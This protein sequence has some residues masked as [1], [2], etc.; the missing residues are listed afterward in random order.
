M[1][2][3]VSLRI[4]GSLLMMF[5]I[6][7]VPP[8]LCSWIFSDGLVE[9]F[10]TALVYTFFS[11]LVLRVFFLK[12]NV[13]MR[14]RDGFLITVIYYLALGSF[15]ALPF[16]MATDLDMSWQDALFESFSGLTTTGATVL[17]GLDQMAPSLLYYRQQLQWLGGMGII[18]LAVAI[19]PMLGI[20]G[21]QL[22]RA[23]TPGPVKD[24]KM[25]P[26]IKG[27]AIALWSIYLGLTCICAISYWL[28]GMSVFDAICHSFSTLAIGGFSTHD[29]SIGYFNSAAIETVAI[30]FMIIAGMNFSLHFISWRGRSLKHYLHDEEAVFYLAVL[31]V[32]SIVVIAGLVYYQVHALPQAI[33]LGVFQVVSLY[34]TTG[35]ATT[36]FSIWPVSLSFL[37]LIGAFAGACAGSTGGGLKIMRVL[38]IYKQGIREI[39]RLIHPNAIFPIKLNHRPVPTK[40]VEAVWG[41]FSIYVIAFLTMLVILMAFGLDFV[42]AFSAI[43]ASINN[44][45]P[46]LGDVA[47]NYSNI[48]GP[49]KLLL[50]FA[51][52]L[53]RLEIFPILVVFTPMFW[54]K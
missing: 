14:I 39:Q 44:L 24:N 5:S 41:F 52:I 15:G 1:H 30:I 19:L 47:Q 20:G 16:F 36:N 49:A 13:E 25:T 46:G 32:A 51:M 31:I 10:T 29:A 18:V 33:R 42:T 50:C 34:T 17:T 3:K 43:G 35:F 4:L 40:V 45:G 53:G 23:E 28:A 22:Y 6:T 21:M 11:G 48:G 27:T 37:L 26:R 8:I 2:L 12:Q 7:L 9:M 54:K 38:L